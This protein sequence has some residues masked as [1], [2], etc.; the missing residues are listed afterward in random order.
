MSIFEIAMLVCFG[1]A[2]PLSIWKS[3][4]SKRN[5]GKSLLFL[6]VIFFGYICGTMN[7]IIYN[8]DYV[9]FLYILNG[10]MVLI[11]ILLYFRNKK[12]NKK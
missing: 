5:E 1:A 2:W 9:I 12:F 8:F 10:L 11:D 4:T 3:Y 6:F 7:K